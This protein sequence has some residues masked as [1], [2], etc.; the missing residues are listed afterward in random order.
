MLLLRGPSKADIEATA[1]GAEHAFNAD[2]EL[3]AEWKPGLHWYSVRVSSGDDVREVGKGQIDV[4]PDFA[5]LPAGYDGRTQNEIAL[6][7]ILAVLAKRATQD[8]M[9]YTI[10]NRELWRTPI[11][12]LLALKAS[13]VAAVRRERAKASGR[14]RFGRA[15]PVRFSS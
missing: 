5:N 9:R 4:L 12:D 1:A 10:D 11:N 14:S 8:Q 3:T 7:S 13:Y 15:I 6:D 2:A